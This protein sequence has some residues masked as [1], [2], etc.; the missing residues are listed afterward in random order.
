M[1]LSTRR[2]DREGAR[3]GHF[4]AFNLRASYS[5]ENDETSTLAKVQ[6]FTTKGGY[7]AF[8]AIP[9]N[10]SLGRPLDAAA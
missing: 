1:F 4:V 5:H 6:A 9:E 2:V 8:A 10:R 7:S 3:S